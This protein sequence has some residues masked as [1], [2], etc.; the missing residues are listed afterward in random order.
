LLYVC[1]FKELENQ[2][3][4]Q[5]A[6]AT[7][8]LL[9]ARVEKDTATKDLHMAQLESQ[10]WKQEAA[11]TKASVSCI[12][13]LDHSF[14]NVHL[15]TFYFIANSSGIDCMFILSSTLSPVF[16]APSPK[17]AHQTES[18]TSQLETITQLRREVNQW[19]DQSKN[20]QEHFLRVEQERC[21]QSSRID[22]LILEKLQVS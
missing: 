18:S 6:H 21:A 17:I 16:I 7:A 10:S 13:G 14:P 8:E 5:I 9:D 12:R 4:E 15:C 19:K 11:A 2:A 20:W 1:Q 22:E 3:R